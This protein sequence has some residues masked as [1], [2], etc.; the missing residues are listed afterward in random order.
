MALKFW[1]ENFYVLF[2]VPCSS[3]PE[4][5]G[6]S[7]ELPRS[8]FREFPNWHNLR[9]SYVNLIDLMDYPNKLL[10]DS[11][12]N[13]MLN[14][15][16]IYGK[17]IRNLKNYSSGY[18]DVLVNLSL[19]FIQRITPHKN[20]S[21]EVYVRGR[22]PDQQ[23]NNLI[24]Q[25]GLVSRYVGHPIESMFYRSVENRK[26]FTFF[27]WLDDIFKNITFRFE[28]IKVYVRFSP[29]WFAPSVNNKAYFALHSPNMMPQIQS[30][31][32]FQ[33]DTSFM[34]HY[35]KI[36]THLLAGNYETKCMNYDL[37]N[38]LGVFNM[39]S[40]CQFNCLSRDNPFLAIKDNNYPL[41]ENLLPDYFPDNN[42]F[43]IETNDKDECAKVCPDQCFHE[44]YLVESP[45]KESSISINEIVI[46]LKRSSMPNVIITHLPEITLIS[47]LC[48]FG[49][50]VGMWLGI[51]I[52]GILNSVV[53]KIC[54]ILI[55]FKNFYLIIT[56]NRANIN[57]NIVMVRPRL[58]LN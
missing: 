40:D 52:F 58:F 10:N 43:N 7:R 34:I 6:N 39:Q 21:V 24:K 2:P 49:G 55:K 22:I 26:C 11:Y 5:S 36:Q 38:H 3:F 54:E 9:N 16:N 56:N 29:L 1:R 37:K 13:T 17:L 23:A 35:T 48:N 15:R 53:H 27:N 50:L 41:R 45:K 47:L 57:Y 12:T 30:F 28:Y 19:P 32:P 46:M 51:S 25:I 14:Y 44:Y 18:R 8:H 4:K 42:K 20:R 31:I 33:I